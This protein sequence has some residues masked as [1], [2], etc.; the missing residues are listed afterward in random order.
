M[1]SPAHQ[2]NTVSERITDAL[3]DPRRRE[4]VVV[5][6]LAAYAV[7]WAIYCTVSTSAQELHSDMTE[8][9]VLARE[10]SFGYF[11]HPPMSIWLAGLWFTVLP[12]APWA[13]Y[14]LAMAM[15]AI[16]LWAAWRL[17][18]RW[19]DAE[20]RIVALA[21]LTFVPFYNFHALKY[22][23][24]TV[25]IPFWAL[26]TLWF[27]RSLETRAPLYAALA[28]LAAAGAMLGKYWSIF[29]LAGL[30][31]AALADPR[32]AAYFRSSAPWITVA[33]GA[34]ALAPH[35]QWL[36]AHDF[37]PFGYATAI[38]VS[39]SLVEAAAG[40]L[41]Y[42]AGVLA[43]AC[44]AIAI[45]LLA[46]R[47]LRA[48]LADMLLPADAA[49]RLP[50]VAFWA[51]LLLPIPMALVA[52]IK[53]T[54]LWIMPA[55]TLLPVVLLSSPFVQFDR[56]AVVRVVTAALLFPLTMA[57]LSPA[58]GVGMG[59]FRP[60]PTDF[61]QLAG[62]IDRA[63]RA[64]TDRPLR[65]VAGGEEIVYGTAFHLPSRPS[66]FLHFNL[67]LN[68]YFNEA[69]LARE[70]LAAVCPASDQVCLGYAQQRAAAVAGSR[71]THAEIQGGSRIKRLP[72]QPYVIVTV[73]P[74][75]D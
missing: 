60:T 13:Y 1:T 48:G 47:P 66:A 72:P 57:V 45:A 14:L 46:A 64:T 28:G 62:A 41:K 44:V 50:A 31:V 63:W 18:A 33:V 3:L 55:L 17:A 43:Y 74:R 61:H 68:P 2:G 37:L 71:T 4:R 8:A 49:R 67:A 75:P 58:I 38:H 34:I 65:I 69:R 70:G 24:N 20:K 12:L 40:A 39:R 25:L 52:G 36:V 51:P 16:G 53:L 29:L 15:P 32:R 54:D 73:P 35:A 19:L 21:L 7:L 23:A 27:A 22:N 9:A 30:G 56:G 11:K 10:F 5:A 26:T 42:L 59:W 6:A